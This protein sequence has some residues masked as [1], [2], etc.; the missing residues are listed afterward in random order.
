MIL[1]GVAGQRGSGKD[2][3]ADAL[4]PQGFLN[5][6][7]AGPLKS[8]LCTLLQEAGASP[9][10]LGDML[11]G[12]LRD[13][14]SQ[15]LCGKTPR[16]AMQTLGTEWRNLIGETLWTQIIE[17][18]LLAKNYK[19]VVISDVRFP[20]EVEMI[21]RLGGTVIRLRRGAYTTTPHPS[22]AQI[23]SLQADLEFRNN[24]KVE[25][26]AHFALAIAKNLESK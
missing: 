22:E 12:N 5:I 15:L 7:F 8:M 13:T 2:T 4:A 11:H 21:H 1:I 26:L 23:P 20:H 3:F 10:I 14:P 6:K 24:G 25:D 19:K 17:N 9:P 16:H 18:R